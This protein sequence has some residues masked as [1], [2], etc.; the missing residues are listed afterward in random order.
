LPFI[1]LSDVEDNRALSLGFADALITMF[2][3][4]EDV[5]VAPTAAIMNYPAGTDGARA[6]RDLGVRYSLQ[7]TV[8][9][10]GGHWRVSMQLFDATIQKIALSDTHD[11][12]L[13]SVFDVQDEVG[14]RIVESLQRRFP[15][16]MRRSR[17]RYSNDPGA[18]NEFIAGLRDSASDSVDTLRAAAE[19]LST[20]TERDPEFALAY[21]TRSLVSMNLHFQFDAQHTRLQQA[22]DQ[23]RTALALDPTLPEG[24][25]ARAWILWS[26]A[27]NFQHAEAIA[28]LQQVLVA[29]PNHERAHN[30]MSSI[31]LHIG[32]LE[33]A[34][35][36]HERAQRATSDTRSGNLEWFYL[37]SGD[38]ARAEETTAAWLRDRPASIYARIS[39]ALP[40]LF[41]GDLDLADERL[42]A[43]AT[44]HPDEPLIVSLQGILFAR[45]DQPDLALQCV[46]KALES[47]RSFGHTHHTY[48]Y[49]AGV[50]AVLGQT[51]KALAWLERSVDTGWA[52]WPFFRIDPH[53]E[54]LREVPAFKRLIADLEQRYTAL[55]IDRL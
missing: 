30:R 23:C 20:A 41:T 47:P 26:P 1:F 17:D 32:R 51:E 43:A 21:A 31:C 11:F 52:C 50:H 12:T 4:L 22:E 35:I 53:F 10:L 36:A 39:H 33:E 18:Y 27:K 15:S 37:M 7:G 46:R 6:C 40:A 29:R 48:H 42:A 45:R 8:Q 28:A 9:K 38:Y 2:A 55:E 13:Q 44:H 14:R 19:H 54:N 24:H 34:R 49:I 3:T 16:S 25:L 5:I